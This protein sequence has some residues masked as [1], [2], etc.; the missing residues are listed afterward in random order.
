[1]L[2]GYIWEWDIFS[3]TSGAGLVLLQQEKNIVSIPREENLLLHPLRMGRI[4]NTQHY[5]SSVGQAKDVVC[6]GSLSNSEWCCAYPAHW[7]MYG[8]SQYPPG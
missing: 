1:M 3:R 7:L 6:S 5:F 2:Y 4:P 8:D